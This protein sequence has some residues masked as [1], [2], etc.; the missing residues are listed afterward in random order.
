MI[1]GNLPQVPQGS[2]AVPRGITQ[3]TIVGV[4]DR[5][6]VS[7]VLTR[8]RGG[9][10]AYQNPRRVGERPGNIIDASVLTYPFSG[11]PQVYHSL[12]ID[13]TNVRGVA[14]RRVHVIR[15]GRYGTGTYKERGPGW[16][17]DPGGGLRRRW[18]GWWV[19]VQWG[20]R[21]GAGCVWSTG[22]GLGVQLVNLN[23]IRAHDGAI[24]PP[25]SK[26]GTERSYN[27]HK[28]DRFI[29]VHTYTTHTLVVCG[30]QLRTD[31][32]LSTRR[33]TYIVFKS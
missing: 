22:V 32:Q 27:T 7:C 28:K 8:R 20:G 30:V 11:V 2:R 1:L 3:G 6:W 17:S 33:S 4:Q 23:V 19:G 16:R 12:P 5:E 29:L 9:S 14:K 15:R 10:W 21:E 18:V 25:L 26:C 24:L 31:D 13:H